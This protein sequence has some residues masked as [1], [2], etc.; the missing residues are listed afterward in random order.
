MTTAKDTQAKRLKRVLQTIKTELIN[1]A[2][3]LRIHWR[4]AITITKELLEKENA[5]VNKNHQFMTGIF[6][7]AVRDGY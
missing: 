4:N 7:Y 6:T 3:H 2:I 5:S 1:T